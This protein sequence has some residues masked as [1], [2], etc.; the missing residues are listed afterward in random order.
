MTDEEKGRSLEAEI[1]RRVS[2]KRGESQGVDPKIAGGFHTKPGQ[3]GGYAKARER[4]RKLIKGR[5]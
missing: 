2:V 3:D 1:Q 5:Y 4:A